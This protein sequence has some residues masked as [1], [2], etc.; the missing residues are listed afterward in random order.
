[1]HWSKS[2][3]HGTQPQAVRSHTATLVGSKIFVF[4]GS[5][6]EDK[7]SDLMVFDTGLRVT[8]FVALI[9]LYFLYHRNHV[10]VDA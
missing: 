8:F 9:T 5:N 4:G 3:V 2:A 7:F 10:L 1:M 6:L